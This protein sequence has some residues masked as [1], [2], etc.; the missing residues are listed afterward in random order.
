MRLIIH[1]V[2]H[3]TYKSAPVPPNPT[4]TPANVITIIATLGDNLNGLLEGIES[5]IK[6]GC[7]H[8]SICV[9]T[10]EFK[11]VED[12]LKGLRKKHDGVEILLSQVGQANK[13]QQLRAAIENVPK[14]RGDF[15]KVMVFADD[16]I[17]CPRMTLLWM[18]ACFEKETVGAVGTCQRTRR[19]RDGSFFERIV[20]WILA[21]Y[22]ERRNFE[23]PATLAIDGSISCLS[24]RMMAIRAGITQD[25]LFLDGLVS[26]AWRGRRLNADDDNFWTRWLLEHG[27]EIGFQYTEECEVETTFELGFKQLLQ[28]NLRWCRSNWRSNFRSIC[29]RGNWW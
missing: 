5:H 23:N 28:R 29:K 16:D 8:F 17:I 18:L 21:D 24:G 2:S 25:C 20:D 27:W 11:Q 9:P 15:H 22:I 1:T 4:I 26:E 19:S 3:G 12:W 7:E 13:R 10:A 6:A 14:Q